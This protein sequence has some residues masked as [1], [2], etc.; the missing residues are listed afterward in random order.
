MAFAKIMQP[1]YNNTSMQMNAI[2]KFFCV[3][4][5]LLQQ[6]TNTNQIQY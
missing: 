5:M 2:K 4:K 3:I 1:P 6:T